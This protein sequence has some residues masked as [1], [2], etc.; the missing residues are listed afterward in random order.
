LPG[1]AEWVCDS[2]VE[3]FA[4]RS[5]LFDLIELEAFSR[6]AASAEWAKGPRFE[7]VDLSGRSSK[8]SRIAKALSRLVREEQGTETLE[9]GLVCGLIVVGAIAAIAIIGPKVKTMW[10][11]TS[12]AIP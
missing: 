8:M 3:A 4:N 2:D 9:W 7:W 6:S 11:A 1:G 10:D 12:A 5:R